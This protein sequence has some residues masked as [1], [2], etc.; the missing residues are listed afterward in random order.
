M[1][2]AFNPEKEEN[3]WL[4]NTACKPHIFSEC[5]SVGISGTRGKRETGIKR[6][7]RFEIHKAEA[8]ALL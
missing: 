5:N 8:N 7:S 3:F 6:G 2:L 4:A 1:N